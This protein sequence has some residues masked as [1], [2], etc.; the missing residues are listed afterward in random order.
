MVCLWFAV[1]FIVS[2]CAA[3]D[4]FGAPCFMDR[5]HFLLCHSHS[6]GYLRASAQPVSVRHRCTSNQGVVLSRHVRV[7]GWQLF[8][9]FV[10]S[11]VE[12]A[13]FPWHTFHFVTLFSWDLVRS[14][15]S[16]PF[17]MFHDS[18]R[19]GMAMQLCAKSQEAVN[20]FFYNNN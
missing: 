18:D 7:P 10:F 6:L 16:L 4:H 17:F 13:G 19:H 2:I 9:A 11:Q 14:V 20:I 3:S 15:M 5:W 8:L 12:V 1:R